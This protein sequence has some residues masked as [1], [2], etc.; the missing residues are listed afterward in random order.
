MASGVLSDTN[1]WRLDINWNFPSAAESGSVCSIPLSAIN[2]KRWLPSLSV[3]VQLEGT[4]SLNPCAASVFLPSVLPREKVLRDASFVP[5]RRGYFSFER[6]RLTTKFPFGLLKKQWTVAVGE[7]GEGF[8]VY[9]ALLDLTEADYLGFL[10]GQEEMA[11]SER[12]GEGSTISG[13]RAFT[14]DDSARRIHW[15]AT[16]RH[17]ELLVRETDMDRKRDVEIYWPRGILLS[18]ELVSFTASLVWGFERR[19]H[20]VRFYPCEGR[21]AEKPMEY[22]SIVELEQPVARDLIATEIS[23]DAG[24]INVRMAYEQWKREQ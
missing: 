9:P 5:E 17:G 23:P 15:K 11:V 8:Y 10:A 7:P 14:P 20:S 3:T 19:G 16:A 4:L 22:L 24:K 2:L 6:I 21:M 1:L 13:L 18:E 12:R